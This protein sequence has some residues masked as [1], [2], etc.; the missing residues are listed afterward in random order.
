MLFVPSMLHGPEFMAELES[1][2]PYGIVVMFVLLKHVV[3]HAMVLRSFNAS[4]ILIPASESI[5]DT[6]QLRY[7]SNQ[8][9][10]ANPLDSTGNLTWVVICRA[11]QLSHEA[12]ETLQYPLLYRPL[13]FV[14]RI[15]T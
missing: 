5:T 13:C 1:Y 7:D 4:Y 8:G 12:R 10:L 6:K 15:R 9:I 14:C 3:V 11:K 2:L